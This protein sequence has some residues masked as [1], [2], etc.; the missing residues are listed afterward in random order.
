MT[1]SETFKQYKWLI[2]FSVLYIV[3][4]GAYYVISGN[5]E[6]LAY[7]AVLLLVGGIVIGTAQTSKIKP[8]TLWLLSIWGLIHMAGGSVRI[9]DGVL[10]GWRIFEFLDFGGDFF[11]LKMDQVIHVYGF[12]VAALIVYQLIKP[13]IANM[14][15]GLL[16]FLAIIGSLGLSAINE[17]VEF[18][19]MVAVENNGVGDIYNMGLDLVFNGIG[20]TLGAFFEH[21]RQ[22]K[23]DRK[24]AAQTNPKVAKKRR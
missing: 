6:F 7:L 8:F 4:F 5:A 23:F 10:Y 12:F 21:W 18:I 24:N 2:A 9:G 11:I 17:I 19:A 20:A 13:R 16:I 3:G 22:S 1:L 14:H 15:P